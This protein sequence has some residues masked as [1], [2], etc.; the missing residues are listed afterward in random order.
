MD[1]ATLFKHWTYQVF[2]P[3]VLLRR[4]YDAFKSLLNHDKRCHELMA[5]IEEIYHSQT[6]VDFVVI[7]RKCNELCKRVAAMIE[8][9]S[10]M[11]PGSYPTLKDH[12]KKIS[13]YINFIFLPPR[14]ATSPPYTVPLLNASRKNDFIMLG[15]KA[16]N[17]TKVSSEAG[18]P[19][20]KGFVITTNA[21][22]FFIEF[23]QL[24]RQIDDKLANLDITST[25]M[26]DQVSSELMK[27]IMSGTIPPELERAIEKE[28]RSFAESVPAGTRLAM[29]SSAV[30]EDAE[31]S[32]AGQYRTVLNV[33][34]S[35]LLDAW[36][37]VIASKYSPRALYYRISYG[38]SDLETPMAVLALEMLDSRVSGIIYTDDPERP[39]AGN[40]VIHAIWGLGELLVQG[41]VSSDAYIVSRGE[42][43]QVLK[44]TVG[45]KAKEMRLGKATEPE[46]VDVPA[47]RR[48]A[49]TLQD[50]EVLLL[51][52]WG[53]KLEQVFQGPQDIEW[54]K[55]ENGR[56]VILQSRPLA[57]KSGDT[58]PCEC[59]FGKISNPVLISGG[60]TASPGIGAGQVFKL[61]KET[62]LEKV[63]RGAVLVAE[64][65]LP[66][67]VK[68]MDK[69]NAVVT[70]VGST[71]GHFAS[72]AREFGVPTLVNT[73]EA[74][75]KIEHG[76]EVTVHADGKT[77]YAGIIRS[78]L[79]KP[80]ARRKTTQETPFQQKL[81][82]L[83]SFISPL[84]LLDPQA[85]NFVPEECQ[86]LH[87][88]IRFLHEKAV[89]EM[90][91]LGD[92]WGRAAKGARRLVSNLPLSLFVVDVGGGLSEEAK[93][94]NEIVME[95]VIS[96]P[97][98]AL[99]QGLTHPSVKWSEISHFDWKEFDN[100]A[101]AGGVSKKSS[102][103][104][105]TYAV[106]SRDYLNLSV[107]F[108]YHFVIVD[109]I[110]GENPQQNYISFRFAGGGG[111][112]HQRGLRLLFLSEILNRLG[113]KV[114]TKG[115]LLDA[116]FQGHAQSA[117]EKRLAELG[118]LIG[119]TR[120]LDM[121]LKSEEDV[122]AFIDDFMAGKSHFGPDPLVYRN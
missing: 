25:E 43:P 39:G 70:D 74:T 11:C 75:S 58:E 69:L 28:Y 72:V 29:R 77:V 113:F 89:S 18:L 91:S 98:R 46:I 86:S 110:C 82:Y 111:L 44:K 79:E 121:Y 112:P 24:R 96:I 21:F 56:I 40:I 94:K 16:Y 50:D 17:L 60:E 13:S 90:F 10:L 36:K 68:I 106:I 64:N 95:E 65:T 99:W 19:I 55:D 103:S 53:M 15:G 33:D 12:F 35:S 51:A 22:N 49:F 119:A 48:K 108:G 114:V 37:K 3:G 105:A 100:I 34:H 81:K 42:N 93:N 85:P 83:V 107:K 78:M 101:L 120:L 26:L 30:A 14:S 67:Y 45:D 4:K 116:Q 73:K 6:K 71:A 109:T 52:R 32:F 104:L 1:L 66:H 92:K 38:L 80:C 76:I 88:I 31:A 62:D 2:S 7:E 41:E 84:R 57:L 20:P 97:L 47:A 102:K 87:D 61:A 115:D 122:R 5:E 9:F 54:A 8:D 59:D 27:M 118:R 23:N 117:T 63:P